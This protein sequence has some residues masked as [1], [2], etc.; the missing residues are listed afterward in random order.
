MKRVDV[1]S[2]LIHDEQGHILIVL[3]KKG[4]SSYWSL[5]AGAVE[6][7]DPLDATLTNGS[8][9]GTAAASF[10]SVS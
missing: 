5:P 6:A 3:D 9:S 2:A 7:G 10:P 4:E 8:V 1:V